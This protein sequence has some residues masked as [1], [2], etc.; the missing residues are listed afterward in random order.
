MPEGLSRL[1][2]AATLVC[3]CQRR[4]GV[5]RTCRQFGSGGRRPP[6]LGAARVATRRTDRL[7]HG[8]I[9]AITD[10]R[11]EH[12]TDCWDHGMEYGMTAR[13]LE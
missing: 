1:T 3:D 6:A 7:E 2:R 5:A 12:R 4:G 9:I 8:T 13:F 10:D 11:L